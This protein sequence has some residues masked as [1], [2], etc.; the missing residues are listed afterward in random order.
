MLI[1]QQATS[2]NSVTKWQ[3]SQWPNQLT[4]Q[5]T[6]QLKWK[7]RILE[8]F[9]V[10]CSAK[11]HPQICILLCDEWNHFML[12]CWRHENWQRHIFHSYFVILNISNLI[13]VHFGNET[14]WWLRLHSGIRCVKLNHQFFDNSNISNEFNFRFF[15]II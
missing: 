8:S 13:S 9:I 14:Q 12:F 4:N 10:H 6:N 3:C 1:W 11:V 7:W 2:H 15:H 5:L